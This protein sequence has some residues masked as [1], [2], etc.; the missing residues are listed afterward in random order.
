M[1]VES[2]F[3]QNKIDG[4]LCISLWPQTCMDNELIS[5]FLCWPTC[6]AGDSALIPRSGRSP[7]E[8]QSYP[9]QYSCLKNPKD[10][11]AWR[12][13]VHGVTKSQ[14]RLRTRASRAPTLYTGHE[15]SQPVVSL[16]SPAVLWIACALSLQGLLPEPTDTPWMPGYE[17]IV[18][19]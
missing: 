1:S 13:T 4:T 2:G 3:L 5:T 17:N 16:E 15:S 18:C 11:G 12:A 7:G 9:L 14:T 8:G 10:R 19:T 6:N